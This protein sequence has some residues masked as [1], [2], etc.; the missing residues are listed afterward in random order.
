MRRFPFTAGS[1]FLVYVGSFFDFFLF[2][3][4]VVF[5][6][7][8][9]RFGVP[10]WG[11]FGA[12]LASFLV[13][14][15]VLFSWSFLVRF[16]VVL[17]CDFGSFLEPKLDQNPCMLFDDFYWF[18]LGF[19]MIFALRRVLFSSYVGSFFASFF[20]SIFGRFLVRFWG[21]FGRL[22]GVTIDLFWH[23]FWASIFD[24]FLVGFWGHLG[25]LLGS[26]WASKSVIFGIDF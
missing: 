11:Y 9:H 3:F 4:R 22:W 18:S 1:G 16:W 19:S 12:M 24:R 20:A 7:F 17:G 23:R 14:F 26:F 21:H 5:C 25:R 2:F 15:F 6:S 10:C 8:L 13:L